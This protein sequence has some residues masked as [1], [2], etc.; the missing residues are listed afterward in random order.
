MFNIKRWQD[1]CKGYDVKVTKV[2][3]DE[4]KGQRSRDNTNVGLFSSY[5]TGAVQTQN[6]VCCGFIILSASV[7]TPSV[8]KIGRWLYQNLRNANK[9]TI[10]PI[11][12]W[13]EKWK[14]DPESVSGTGA[15]P[16]VNRFFRLVGPIIT[17]SFYLLL[18]VCVAAWCAGPDLRL[19]SP[20]RRYRRGS[21]WL[22]DRDL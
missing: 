22:C 20:G 2:D 5:K 14:S 11:P 4:F 8:V 1:I 21:S 19:E 10:S 17:P 13:W 9:S 12:Q 18:L 15:P 16:K 6:T 3:S 7:I